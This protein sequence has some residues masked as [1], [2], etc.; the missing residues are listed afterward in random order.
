MSTTETPETSRGTSLRIAILGASGYTGAELV[1]LLVEHPLAQIVALTADRKVG[2][3]LGAVFPHL[4]GAVR[5]RNLPLL[6]PIDA[7]DWQ[8]VDVAFLALPHGAAQPLAAKVPDHVR[9][10]DLSPDFRFSDP[11]VYEQWYG[12]PH[13]AAELQRQ[14]VYG[15]T[16][17]AR[18]RLA[19][20]RL[21]ACPGCYCTAS[22]LP[23]L[24][25]AADN[26]I[27]VEDIVIDAKSGTSGAGR[28]AKE[29]TLFTE[30]A[31]GVHA[32][33]VASHRHAPEIEEQVSR[34]TG[35]KVVLN[36]TPH[37]M[38]MN[39]GILASIY[40][41]LKGGASAADIRSVMAARYAREPFVHVLE[42]GQ[43]PATRHVRGSNNNLIAVFADRIEGRAIV[44]SVIDNLV[45]GAS[46][47]AIQNMNFACGLAET[48]GLTQKPLF[49]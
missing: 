15:L 40:V 8:G 41:R 47:Q 3:D 7:V 17:W 46:G 42:E 38:P 34:V 30:V 26:L 44:L 10:L 39:R 24:P 14:V 12:R 48:T 20:A 9:L 36:F 6:T 28:A 4:A 33:G 25:L 21:I 18:P 11:A 35:H 1:R 32:Y 5:A 22:L 43:V 45:K 13:A 29:E 23:L 16:E 31:E 37:L 2:Q 19:G 49:P 27:D